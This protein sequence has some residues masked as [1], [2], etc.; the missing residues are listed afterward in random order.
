[1][2]MLPRG[3]SMPPTTLKP[4]PFFPGPFSNSTLWTLW[5]AGEGAIIRGQQATAS[6]YWFSFDFDR[7]IKL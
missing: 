6:Y 7:R 4:S 1:M 5:G 2:P 3:E